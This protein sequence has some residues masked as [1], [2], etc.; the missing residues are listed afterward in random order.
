MPGIQMSSAMTYNHVPP[1][2]E[3]PV[4]YGGD[5]VAE[6]VGTIVSPGAASFSAGLSHEAS[7]D[8]FLLVELGPGQEEIG[9]RQAAL[10]GTMC[11]FRP[12]HSIEAT[13]RSPLN[14]Y[15][16]TASSMNNASHTVTST[17][18]AGLAGKEREQNPPPTPWRSL[19][20]ERTDG[21]P[22]ALFGSP[23]RG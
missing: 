19:N 4:C 9:G 3:A 16:L 18:H 12:T 23:H 1:P 14:I 2:T 6:I 20:P 8:F 11:I 15:G 7:G 5:I 22:H 17:R 21:V 10:L 13:R